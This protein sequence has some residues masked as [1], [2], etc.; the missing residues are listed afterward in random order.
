MPAFV[1]DQSFEG[2]LTVIFEAFRQKTFPEALLSPDD[3]PPLLA[4]RIVEVETDPEKAGR[5]WA[6]LEKK[7]SPLALK[8]FIYAWLT[9][10]AA[11]AELAVRY[12][13]AVFGG[14]RETDFSHPDVMGL[15]RTAFKVGREKEQML[16]F[17]RFQKTVDGVYFAA[18][19]PVYNVVPLVL[20]HF[21]DRFADQ[22][23]IIYDLGR[24]FGFY[25]DLESL[26]EIDF[27]KPVDQKTGRL[28]EAELAEGE[29]LLQEAWRAY[30]AAVS[31]PERANPRLQRQ[32][33]PKRFWPYLTEKQ[34]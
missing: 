14:V 11:E 25:Y 23:W 12:V 5:V 19:N 28:N 10:E 30:F 34:K 2:L 33:M 13:R 24:G 31:I 15:R 17:V 20:D 32:Y 3:D 1:Y 9:G 16:Q 7:L 22:K 29:T 21:A 26:C 4:S 6:G 8:Q 18:V 27:Y